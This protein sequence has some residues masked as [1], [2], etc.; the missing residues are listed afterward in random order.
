[1]V[2]SKRDAYSTLESTVS[3]KLAGDIDMSLYDI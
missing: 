1:L 2:E 3:S